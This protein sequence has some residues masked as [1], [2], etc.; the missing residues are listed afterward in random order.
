MDGGWELGR[1]RKK[2]GVACVR[3]TERDHTEVLV[4]CHRGA[5]SAVRGEKLTSAI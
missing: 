1:K 3:D 2:H 4:Q 5:A